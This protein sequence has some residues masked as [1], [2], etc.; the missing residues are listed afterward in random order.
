MRDA[1]GGEVTGWVRRCSAPLGMAS[2]F[3]EADGGGRVAQRTVPAARSTMR[4][5]ASGRDTGTACDASMTVVRAPARA[6]M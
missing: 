5:T 1:V 3:S 2:E 6:D 4:A